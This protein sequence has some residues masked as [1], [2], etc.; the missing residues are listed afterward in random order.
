MG[1]SLLT[2]KTAV[3]TGLALA[4]GS[5]YGA[6]LEVKV[7]LAA[8]LT[9]GS[10]AYGKDC[11]NGARIAIE[12]A[13]AAHLS[14]GGKTAH[15]TLISEDDQGDPRVGVQVAQKLVDQG[16]S[17]VIGHANSGVSI[18]ASGVY[19][20]A[21]V[22]MITPSASAP[23]LTSQG[24]DNVFRAIPNDV[25][26]A[27]LAGTY[28][29]KKLGA[30]R[31]AIID[32]REAFGQGE[33]DEF[34]K[35]VK[36]AGGTV[37]SREYTTEQAVDYSAQLTKFKSVDA[38]LVYFGA[39]DAQSANLVKRMKQLNLKANFLGGGAVVTQQFLTTGGKY[40]E[41]ARAFE[42]GEPLARRASG[43]EF[44]QKFKAKFG[45]DYHAYAPFSYDATWAAVKAMQAS[46]SNDPKTVTAALHKLSFEGI[47]GKI[48]FDSKGDVSNPISTLY[49]VKSGKWEVIDV[50][51]K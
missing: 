22:P 7:G 43:R 41:G 5:T 3:A 47:T 13:N 37:I 38:D 6:D 19:A 29:V 20:K 26:N 42:Y 1:I 12:E 9:G 27:S 4:L 48:S 8:P 44:A 30:K 18:P 34:E 32:D 17:V 28:A 40:V 23:A 50:A 31:I 39:L 35:A 33:A 21:G 25:Q 2:R 36:A 11:E 15:F 49:E 51:G 14:I 24:L 10:A 46:G 45:T 16:V